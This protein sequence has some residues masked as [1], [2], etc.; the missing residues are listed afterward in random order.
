MSREQSG[1]SCISMARVI[2]KLP[3]IAKRSLVK[4]TRLEFGKV[5]TSAAGIE[6]ETHRTVRCARLRS[7][8][9]LRRNRHSPA[10]S[11]QTREP[12]TGVVLGEARTDSPSLQTTSCDEG[13]I[14]WQ[15]QRRWR[16][17][18]SNSIGSG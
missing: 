2:G 7:G 1:R 13:C 18:I 3:E 11:H 17:G 9:E 14:A 8:G 15:G 10:I 12:L 5:R 6:L 4:Q 16:T